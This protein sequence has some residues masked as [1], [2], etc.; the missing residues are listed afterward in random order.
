MASMHDVQ[1]AV[2]I[3]QSNNKNS[4]MQKTGLSVLFTAIILVQSERE[5]L[6]K[7][8]YIMVYCFRKLAYANHGQLIFE[9][10]V[11]LC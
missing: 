1:A 4:F 3:G 6:D 7:L 8:R 11:S 2:I 10:Q 5:Y 9:P